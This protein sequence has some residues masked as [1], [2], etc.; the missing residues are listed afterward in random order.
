MSHDLEGAV[1]E[2]STLVRVGTAI[3][4]ERYVPI[5]GLLVMGF[6]SASDEARSRGTER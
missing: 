6:L 1:A 4:S 3:F 5:P 2:G